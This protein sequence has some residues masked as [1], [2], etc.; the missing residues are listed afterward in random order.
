MDFGAIW[1]WSLG[2]RHVYTC[3]H[4][5]H[6]KTERKNRGGQKVIVYTGVDGVG[7][8]AAWSTKTIN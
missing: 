1:I 6:G 4:F 8:Y 2:V 3:Y 7:L 5:R